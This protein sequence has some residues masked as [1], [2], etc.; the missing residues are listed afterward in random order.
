[1]RSRRRRSLSDPI[2]EMVPLHDYERI[3]LRRVGD[4]TPDG[5]VTGVD[6]VAVGG[7]AT[8]GG[9][10]RSLTLGYNRDPFLNE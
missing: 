8:G 9:T 2:I 6:A 5:A 10:E 4:R 1:M 3:T 7:P